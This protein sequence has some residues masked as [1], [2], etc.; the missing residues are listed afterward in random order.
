MKQR[1][2][3]AF[4][5]MAFFFIMS[6]C[7]GPFDEQ[8][9]GK[10]LALPVGTPFEIRLQTDTA[11]FDWE[12]AEMDTSIVKMVFQPQFKA[13]NRQEQAS[14]TTSYFFQTTGKGKTAIRLEYIKE[15]EPGS[16][17]RKSYELLID[18]R[19]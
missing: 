13:N 12:I 11:E 9:H 6:S 15:N 1:M 16:V 8:D 3:T 2:K 14:G 10:F 7:V 18:C 17:P 19:I 5:M 4:W